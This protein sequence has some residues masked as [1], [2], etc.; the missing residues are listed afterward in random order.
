MFRHT[1]KGGG[2]VH[3]ARPKKTETTGPKTR[4]YKGGDARLSPQRARGVPTN[5]G[6]ARRYK[7]KGET[8]MAR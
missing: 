1:S 2:A 7:V 4:H 8:K 3:P 6:K 5:R